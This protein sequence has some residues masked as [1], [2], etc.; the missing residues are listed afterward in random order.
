MPEIAEAHTIAKQ[1]AELVNGYKI[2]SID[3]YAESKDKFKNMEL[4]INKPIKR[5]FAVGKHVV[6]ELSEGYVY[7]TLSMTGKW[8]VQSEKLSKYSKHIWLKI[9]FGKDTDICGYMYFSDT[10]TWG[11]VLY[12]TNDEFSQKIAKLGPDLLDNFPSLE[13][14]SKIIYIKSIKHKVVSDLLG[15]KSTIPDK[16]KNRIIKEAKID[17]ENPIADLNE[18]EIRK[19]YNIIKKEKN[20]S[21]IVSA[22]RIKRRIICEFLI[23][24]DIISGIGNYVRAEVLY[25]AKINPNRFID[26]LDDDE[27]ER[28]HASIKK[29]VNMADSHNGLSIDDKVSN[30][31]DIYGNMGTYP[32]K[33][34]GKKKC[35]LGHDIV[36]FKIKTGGQ[37]I[38]YC[39][40]EQQAQ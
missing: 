8:L 6:F 4:T 34:Y 12:L 16:V 13:E 1:L 37:T 31:V 17:P 39:P 24:Q 20:F 35:P 14:F 29:I 7:T 23:E 18:D 11:S 2:L 40:H 5:I 10:R 27:V 3:I 26:E 22:K 15:S 38:H 19:I 32:A 30:Y 28:L 9:G 25:A 21:K 33:V 36:K